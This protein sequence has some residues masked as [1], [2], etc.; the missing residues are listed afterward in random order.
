L[1][2]TNF[3]DLGATLTHHL[4]IYTFSGARCV[5]VGNEGRPVLSVAKDSAG[6]VDFSDVQIVHNSQCVRL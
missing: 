4:A 3:C 1:I 2:G 6:S 5:P